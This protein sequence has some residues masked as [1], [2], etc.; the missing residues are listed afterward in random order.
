MRHLPVPTSRVL[1]TARSR[2]LPLLAFAALGLAGA[3]SAADP[4][5]PHADPAHQADP[6]SAPHRAL[7][8]GHLRALVQF[9]MERVDAP[10]RE[11]VGE[12]AHAAQGDLETFERR[13]EAARAP[14]T[15]ILLAATI[16]TQALEAARVEEMRIVDERSRRVNRLLLDIASALTPAQRA[17]LRDEMAH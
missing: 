3:C 8:D 1:C 17:R 10:Q 12:L 13:A 4:A 5:Q 9:V 2:L 14:R 6:A 15:N 7:D 11:Q 16:D